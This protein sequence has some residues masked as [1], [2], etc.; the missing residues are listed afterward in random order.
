[1]VGVRVALGSAA[2]LGRPRI[3]VGLVTPEV[4]A[5]WEVG[6]RH[7]VVRGEGGGQR[8]GRE[9]EHAWGRYSGDTAEIWGRYRGDVVEIWGRFGGDMTCARD[10]VDAASDVLGSERRDH[11]EAV[12]AERG[13]EGAAQH[14]PASEG[15]QGRAQ[16]A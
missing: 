7:D 15:A 8:R 10:E 2:A 13:G 12:G 3:G 1:M 14:G 9:L 6:Q 5:E 16:G 4:R 11:L